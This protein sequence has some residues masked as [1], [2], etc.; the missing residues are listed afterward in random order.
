VNGRWAVELS[1]R[2]S[3]PPGTRCKKCRGRKHRV[4]GPSRTRSDQTW[5]T[6]LDGIRSRWIVMPLRSGEQCSTTT[7][8]S[9]SDATGNR[10]RSAT[11]GRPCRCRAVSWRLSRRKLVWPG[12]PSRIGR[13]GSWKIKL[14]GRSRFCGLPRDTGLSASRISSSKRAQMKAEAD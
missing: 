1:K 8:S 2:T 5:K 9:R 13:R 14:T 4:G 7:W 6:A 11:A 3:Q 10:Q 12:L